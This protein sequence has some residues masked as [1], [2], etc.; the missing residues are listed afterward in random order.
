MVSE[1]YLVIEALSRSR[2]E[3]TTSERNTA[4]GLAADTRKY[5]PMRSTAATRAT[6]DYETANPSER[7]WP[8]VSLLPIAA[9]SWTGQVLSRPSLRVR[10]P[11]SSTVAVALQ[12]Q[13]ALTGSARPRIIPAAGAGTLPA[14][15]NPGEC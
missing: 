5:D 10:P 13:T 7:P 1:G 2:A 12:S 14:R 9:N 11:G 15:P 3:S 4:S 8:L 6:S